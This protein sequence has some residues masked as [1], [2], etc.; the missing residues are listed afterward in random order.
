MKRLTAIITALAL[1]AC[2]SVPTTYRPI[3]DTQGVNP[4]Q[5]EQDVAECQQFARQIDAEKATAANAVA[6][7]IFATALGALLGLRGRNLAQVA[8]AGAVVQGTHGAAYANMTQAQIINQCML[9]R[10]YKVLA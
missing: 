8:A 2:A 3:I 10:G 7:A 1:T 5:Y 9:G 6:G 4:A